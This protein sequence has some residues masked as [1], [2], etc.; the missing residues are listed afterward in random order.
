MVLEYKCGVR[1]LLPNGR[2]DPEWSHKHYLAHREHAGERTHAYH[3]ANKEKL[4]ASSREWHSSHRVRDSKRQRKRSLE[5][6]RR[7]VLKTDGKT[8]CAADGCG[9]NDFILQANYVSGGHTRPSDKGMPPT[10]GL[11]P[12]HE[13]TS[14]RADA[15]LFDFLHPPHNAVDHLERIRDKFVKRR[16]N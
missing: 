4:L 1:Y 11:P 12:Y 2:I 14:G 5:I 6:K 3:L 15:K 10:G 13:I 9:C 7:A 16:M 8:M